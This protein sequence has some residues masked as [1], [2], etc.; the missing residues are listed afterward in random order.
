MGR[1]QPRGQTFVDLK[2]GIQVGVTRVTHPGTP[3]TGT[4]NY[5]VLPA[6]AQD[7]DILDDTEGGPSGV[8]FYLGGG[9]KSNIF[10]IDGGSQGDEFLVVSRHSGMV[11]FG[12]E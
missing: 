2:D 9:S 11:N 6:T 10:N 1:I 4:N 3:G 8:T 7:A 12:Q 5:L